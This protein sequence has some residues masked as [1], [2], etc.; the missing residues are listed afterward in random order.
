M[1]RLTYEQR[2]N[3]PDRDFAVI[4]KSATEERERRKYP[5]ENESH[6]RNALARVSRFGTAQEKREVCEKVHRRFPEI[7]EQSC[8]LHR[9]KA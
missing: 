2:K 1:A 3:L 5:I 9:M 7:H 8:K 6:A 4:H